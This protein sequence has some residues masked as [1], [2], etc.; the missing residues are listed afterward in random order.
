MEAFF[1]DFFLPF[2]HKFK[3]PIIKFCTFGGTHWMADWVGNPSPFSYVPSPT[4]LMA[5]LILMIGWGL[6]ESDQHIVR[7]FLSSR[8]TILFLTEN[9]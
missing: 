6:G 1:S 2:G 4:S 7:N 3:A 9:G 8:S 5:S